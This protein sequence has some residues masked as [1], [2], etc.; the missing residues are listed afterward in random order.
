MSARP[1]KQDRSEL[2]E[3]L[4]DGIDYIN[5]LKAVLV[6]ERDALE[7]RDSTLLESSAKT[8]ET[9]AKNLAMFDFFRDDIATLAANDNGEISDSWQ[10]F[11]SIARDCDEL[12]QTNGLIIRSR[13]QQVLTGLAVLQGRDGSAETYT[14]SGSAA[15]TAGKRKLTE[16]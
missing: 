16:V 11:Q 15:A 1:L 13:H 6:E 14:S 12:N 10:T 2:K 3:I 8:K 9:L 5:G 7:R 4:S